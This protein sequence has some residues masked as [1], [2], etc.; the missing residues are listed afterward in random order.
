MKIGDKAK[1][2]EYNRNHLDNDVC[3]YAGM[4][5]TVK[6]IN[7]DGSFILDCGNSILVVPM[8]NAFKQP[9]KGIWIYLNGNHIFHKRIKTKEI[10]VKKNGLIYFLMKLFRNIFV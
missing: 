9:K 5:G 2:S 10:I 3:A 8:R 4:E 1:M 6:D 7:E